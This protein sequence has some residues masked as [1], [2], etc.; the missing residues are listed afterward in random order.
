MSD[1]VTNTNLT[2]MRATKNNMYRGRQNWEE[3]NKDTPNPEQGPDGNPNP[4]ND[5][6]VD[7]NLSP[8][9]KTYAKRYADLR[10]ESQRQ[11]QEHD[12]KLKQMADKIAEL[13][14]GSG[15]KLPVSEAE[16][17]EW[18]AKY[19]ELANAILFAA[20]KTSTAKMKKLK[21][22][23]DKLEEQSL[24]VHREKA[25]LEL[26]KRHPDVD[27][28]RESQEFHDWVEGQPLNIQGWFYENE[29]DFE[30][31][32]RGITLFKLETGWKKGKKKDKEQDDR[33][34][35]SR[36]VVPPRAPDINSEGGNKKQWRE[37]EIMKLKPKEYEKYEEE[38]DLARVEGRV[39]L[40]V[41]NSR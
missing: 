31:A 33:R 17:N 26:K 30:L 24:D 37:S 12:A 14:E 20:D 10:R 2:L 36:T 27:D 1:T 19:P 6:R 40:D 3:D 35:N 32:A 18:M 39:I 21:D 28:I 23:L 41:T 9:E 7:T 25:Y 16:I 15:N 38:I 8:E 29:T 11:K 5:G 4:E 13:E 22:Q 34:E